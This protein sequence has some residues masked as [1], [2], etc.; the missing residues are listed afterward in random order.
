MEQHAILRDTIATTL[1]GDPGAH[2]HLWGFVALQSFTYVF[3][4]YK[5]IGLL[6][7][8]H[9][10]ESG[11][12]VLRQMW[13]VSLNLHWIERDPEPRAQDFCN[14]TVM[15]MRKAAEKTEA[16]LSL[17]D[18]DEATERFQSRFRFRDRR[19]RDRTHHNFSTATV[20]E[21][22]DELGEPWN[23]DYQLIYHLSSMHIHGA[24]GAVLHQHFVHHSSSPETR[25]KDSTALIA[26]LSMKTIV[27]D[28]HLLV[29]QRF[30]ADSEKIDAVFERVLDPPPSPS[31]PKKS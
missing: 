30:A 20:R 9:Y 27:D 10:H 11:A 25:E 17:S 16:P 5:A 4:V 2:H 22:A 8:E 29:R 15:E 24:P 18:F 13:E 3:N 19:G 28:V 26:Y 31:E 23:Q 12:V 1:A 14:F 21:R 6:L 7:P